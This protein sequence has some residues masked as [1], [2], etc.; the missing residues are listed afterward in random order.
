MSRVARTTGNIPVI[1][2][3]VCLSV[4]LSVSLLRRPCP[5]G[6][7]RDG[8][9]R[10][11]PSF[12]GLTY[13]LGRTRTHPLTLTTRAPFAQS[14]RANEREES[15]KDHARLVCESEGEKTRKRSQRLARPLIHIYT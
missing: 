10:F 3:T 11:S 9:G 5:Q 7:R 15:K 1:R 8:Q 12:A 13:N 2:P 4:T 6:T 14:K